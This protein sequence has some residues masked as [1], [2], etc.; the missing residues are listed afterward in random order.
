MAR[1]LAR[2]AVDTSRAALVEAGVLRYRPDVWGDERWNRGFA[3]GHMD[4]MAALHELPRYS[5]LAGFLQYFGPDVEVVDVGCGQGLLRRRVA[6]DSFTGYVG[7]DP[8][9]A[10]I[11]MAKKLED[12]RTSFLVG[13]ISVVGD[14]RFDVAMCNE[15]LSMVPEPE[16]LV[17]GVMGVLK[18]GG[19]VLTSIWRHP[20]DRVL[21]RL[22]DERLERVD[23]VKV[24]NGSSR[25]ARFGW[26]VGC[27]RMR[28]D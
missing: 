16:A 12:E 19:I 1:R 14:R 13:D 5:M 20:G 9:P 17:D 11:A 2:R 18:P 4:Y 26:Q 25:L 15:V 10:A 7:I 21:W 22:L 27:H 8:T 6:P 23:L 24:R 28:A 3:S